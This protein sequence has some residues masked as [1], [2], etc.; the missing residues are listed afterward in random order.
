MLPERVSA[1]SQIHDGAHSSRTVDDEV[2]SQL[3]RG[4]D[5]CCR[6]HSLPELWCTEHVQHSDVSVDGVIA[7]DLLTHL[8]ELLPSKVLRRIRR[9]VMKLSDNG[10]RLLRLTIAND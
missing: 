3:R 1:R 4:H 5:D 10:P 8:V 2:A 7:C 9:I 6:G